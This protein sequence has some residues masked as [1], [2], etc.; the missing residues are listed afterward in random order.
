MNSFVTTSYDELLDYHPLDVYN[1]KV[2]ERV[3]KLIRMRYELGDC[4]Q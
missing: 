2:E 1:L 3:R 4:E